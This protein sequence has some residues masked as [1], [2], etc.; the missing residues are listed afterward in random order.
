MKNQ[1]LRKKNNFFSSVFAGYFASTGLRAKMRNIGVN[2][3][4]FP[5]SMRLSPHTSSTLCTL[6]DPCSVCVCVCVCVCKEF[7]MILH[8]RD[9]QSRHQS[10]LTHTQHRYA[11]KRPKGQ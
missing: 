3:S 11:P 4:N 1:K 8:E 2:M 9:I 7:S 6:E 5:P 10:Y